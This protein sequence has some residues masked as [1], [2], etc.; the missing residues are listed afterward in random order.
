M[1]RSDWSHMAQVCVWADSA[2]RRQMKL[3]Y[4]EDEEVVRGEDGVLRV[5]R[6]RDRD[7]LDE[8]QDAGGEA[9]GV[10]VDGES[11]RGSNREEDDMGETEGGQ[12]TE[13][14]EI[15]RDGQRSIDRIG[16]LRR[17]M[18]GIIQSF[19]DEDSGLRA[20][21]SEARYE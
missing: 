10:V 19:D 7:H 8:Q 13:A 3:V 20:R 2:L 9:G 17:R 5:Q 12:A 6:I 21:E 1:S 14:M 16:D 15:I 4:G 18:Q 11:E